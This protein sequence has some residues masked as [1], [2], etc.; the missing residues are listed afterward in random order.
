[1]KSTLKLAVVICLIYTAGFAQDEFFEPTTTIGGYGELHYN[2]KTVG[3]GETT[4]IT[5]FHRFIIF[6]SHA[7]TES[8]SF[9]SEVELEHNF[10][11]DGQGE[12]ELEQAYV[13]YH[14]EHFGIQ[15]G[16]I[17]P[18]IG[19][20]NEYHEPPL[21][22]S[23]ERPEYAKYIVP[24]TWF[25]NGMALYGKFGSLDWKTVV[26][27]GLNGDNISSKW[28]Q[29]IRG[30]RQ[31]GYKSNAEKLL[32]NLRIDYTG[33]LGLKVGG[34]FSTTEAIVSEEGKN[35]IEI[36]LSE[37]HAKLDKWNVVAV[38]EWGNI[39]YTNH[40][41][42]SSTGYYLD[43]GYNVSSLLKMEGK[44]IPWVR[45][46]DINPGIGHELESSKHYSKWMAGLTYKPI[47]KVAFKV[48]YAVKTLADSEADETTMINFGVGYDF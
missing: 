27:E 34:S 16:V 12:L 37:A 4:K 8:W 30:G 47:N 32:Y 14:S 33:L 1:M 36:Q 31:K 5:D 15:A 6:Y 19:F 22:L 23:V 7:W 25:G 2:Q 42:K 46:A 11:K 45:I 17:L 10:V 21:F 24:T 35:N 20:L 13:N 43:L 41:V 44:L 40:V 9:K 26:M 3:E 29:G 38:F 28:D 39:Q 48:D 18:S